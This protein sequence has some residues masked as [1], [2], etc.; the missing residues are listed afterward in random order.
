MTKDL[1]K[2]VLKY[3]SLASFTLAFINAF[4]YEITAKAS[5]RHLI[6]EFILKNNELTTELKKINKL[7]IYNKF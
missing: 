4:I 1:L 6:Q 7:L 5:A 3:I 2:N